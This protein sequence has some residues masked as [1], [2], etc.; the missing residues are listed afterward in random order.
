[1]APRWPSGA[2]NV[3]RVDNSKAVVPFAGDPEAKKTY[4]YM[5]EFRTPNSVAVVPGWGR[6]IIDNSKAL[7]PTTPLVISFPKLTVNFDR[8]LDDPE[9]A[10]SR[11]FWKALKGAPNSADASWAAE[12]L[13]DIMKSR[14]AAYG[15]CGASIAL[16][17]PFLGTTC[18][19][20]ATKH[21][22]EFVGG[23]VDKSINDLRVGMGETTRN[24]TKGVGDA[25]DAVQTQ[26]QSVGAAV[27][28]A[29]GGGDGAAKAVEGAAAATTLLIYIAGFYIV[30][31]IIR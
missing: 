16:G 30:Y 26:V 19:A 13:A 20:A 7:V 9:L 2:R 23:H 29:V 6:R 5:M 4:D 24:L 15:L 11:A 3:T 10:S 22:V 28:S 12:K 25:I 14:E 17:G 1:M 21:G 8:E 31:R 27:G 18:A